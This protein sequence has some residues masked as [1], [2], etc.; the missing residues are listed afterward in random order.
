MASPPIFRKLRADHKRVLADLD[1]LDR[2]VSRGRTRSPRAPTG[3]GATAPRE[4]ALRAQVEQLGR[5]FATH[6]AAE[7]ETL[8]P[9]LL[10]AMPHT[11]TSIEPLSAEHAEMRVMLLSLAALLE[12]PA[13]ATRDEQIAVQWRDLADL[14]RIHIRKEESLVFIVAEHVLEPRELAELEARRFPDASGR[15][16]GCPSP[17][18]AKGSSPM[19]R[20][21]FL[22]LALGYALALISC[23][24]KKG[25]SDAAGGS[26]TSSP[27]SGASGSSSASGGAAVSAYDSGPRAGEIPI[28]EASV[29]QGQALFKSKGCTACHGFGVKLTCPDMKGVSMRRTTAWME[30]QILHPE[31]M[32]KQDPIAHDL[33]AKFAL[34]MPNQ[35]LT[36]EQATAVIEYL[37]HR[38]H[39][40]GESKSESH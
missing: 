16:A 24:L 13:G 18:Q 21:L 1:A 40:A 4:A 7:D 34:Q 17:S 27:A 2:V 11:R 39:E 37:K 15:R 12:R 32:T 26:A 29:E 19:K 9:A 33:Y 5:Q 3:P 28:D 30:Q 22:L 38:D 14:L 6:M 25:G 23:G 31:V 20:M 10:A 36:P 35:G 8:F